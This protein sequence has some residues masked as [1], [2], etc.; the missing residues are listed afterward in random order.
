MN[1]IYAKDMRNAVKKDKQL[2]IPIY[3][4]FSKSYDIFKY[5]E[6]L[7]IDGLEKKQFFSGKASKDFLPK[8]LPHL[9]GLNDAQS[10]KNIMGC[11]EE[12]IIQAISLLYSR[13]LLQE[14]N[15]HCR[16]PFYE[17]FIDNTRINKNIDEAMDKINNEKIFIIS[18]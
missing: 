2:N 4:Y 12:I 8:L 7:I 9:N 1:K 13:G 18:S 15:I 10:L 17:K 6:R 11:S 3:P 14:G 16:H 5:N